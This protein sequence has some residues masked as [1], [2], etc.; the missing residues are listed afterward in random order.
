M[1]R[2]GQERASARKVSLG[3]MA[4]AI[5]ALGGLSG[6]VVADGTAGRRRALCLDHQERHVRHDPHERQDGLRGESHPSDL[7]VFR[8]GDRGPRCHSVSLN[9]YTPP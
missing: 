3:R 4:S 7:H 8:A 1:K 6:L 5:V 2:V 9:D